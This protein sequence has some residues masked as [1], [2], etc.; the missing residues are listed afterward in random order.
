M[1]PGVSQPCRVG[2]TPALRLYEGEVVGHHVAEG[3]PSLFGVRGH[4][5]VLE[6]SIWS[7]EVPGAVFQ[8]EGE[9]SHQP[10]PL[11]LVISIVWPTLGF[12]T[13][14]LFR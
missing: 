1:L 6:V 7:L 10:I 11:A 5:R 8:D 14:S 13:S 3:A 9:G 4:E 2:D 12:G